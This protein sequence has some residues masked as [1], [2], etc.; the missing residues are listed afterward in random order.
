MISN[1]T[2]QF[3]ALIMKFYKHATALNLSRLSYFTDYLACDKTG[4][5][6]SEFQYRL[7][8]FGPFDEA[9]Y[10]CLEALAADRLINPHVNYTKNGLTY[11]SYAYE[12]AMNDLEFKNEFMPE[13]TVGEFYLMRD[14]LFGL[15]NFD[16][17]R[18]LAMVYNT[19]PIKALGVETPGR[20]S[21]PPRPLDLKEGVTVRPGLR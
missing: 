10:I 19:R 18:L 15:M 12:D 13:V 14:I 21:S 11:V 16:E 3:L 7:T 20:V 5:P 4:R 8:S 6:I 9:I 1:K 2:Q 17:K